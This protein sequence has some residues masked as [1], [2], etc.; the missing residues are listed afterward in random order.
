MLFKALKGSLDWTRK[1]YLPP[2][3]GKF[4]QNPLSENSVKWIWSPIAQGAERSSN[5]YTKRDIVT[6]SKGVG[7]RSPPIHPHMKVPYLSTPRRCNVL[8]GASLTLSPAPYTIGKLSPDQKPYQRNVKWAFRKAKHARKRFSCQSVK[9][10]HFN[11]M[12]HPYFKLPLYAP[13]YL[14]TVLF[15]LTWQT[16]FSVTQA[17]VNWVSTMEFVKILLTS[18]SF[19]TSEGIT[20]AH[21][22]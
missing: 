2:C 13:S 8:L 19:A 21:R 10:L 1:S 7:Q 15:F 5:A 22:M 17:T 11:C 6:H 14:K 16:K 12:I 4:A 9:Q 20:V 18:L 3:R